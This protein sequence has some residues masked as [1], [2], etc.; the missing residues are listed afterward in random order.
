[1]AQDSPVINEERDVSIGSGSNLGK[2]DI[3]QSGKQPSFAHLFV[4][5][6][7]GKVTIRFYDKDGNEITGSDQDHKVLN[8]SEKWDYDFGIGTATPTHYD[9]HDESGGGSNVDH[10][11]ERSTAN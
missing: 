3:P 8:N 7:S 10:R 5:C 6:N 4:T 11:L 2:Q 9:I 1:M